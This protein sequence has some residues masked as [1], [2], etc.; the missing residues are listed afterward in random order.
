MSSRKQNLEFHGICQT[1]N[2]DLVQ[3]VNDVAKKVKVPALGTDDILAIHRLPAK[4][5]KTPGII[6]R[7]SKQ[8]TS[9]EW[10]EMRHDLR[11][12]TYSTYIQEKLTK[13]SKD[14]LFE[15]KK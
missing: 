14:L 1:D 12:T 10:F 9:E 5:G 11:N 8:H 2:E 4:P 15:A 13:M 6:V 7:F 3:K